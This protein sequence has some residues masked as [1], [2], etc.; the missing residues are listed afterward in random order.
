M[1]APAWMPLYV[2]DYLADTG[3]LSTL[4]HGAYLLLI[5]HY[6]QNGSLPTDEKKLARITRMRLELWR[7]LAPQ[8][9]D[10]FDDSWRHERIERELSE[11]SDI[12]SKRSKAGKAGA[13]GRWGK[14]NA[15][16]MA[17]ASKCQIPS[18]TPSPLP[19]KKE[20]EEKV[21]DRA[22]ARKRRVSMPFN[23][24]DEELKSA[25]VNFWQVHA[26][27]DIAA[28]VDIQADQFRDHHA[29]TGAIMADWPAAWRTWYRN[30]LKYNK[31][32]QKHKESGHE[33]LARVSANLIQEFRSNGRGNNHSDQ[34][35]SPE[36][37]DED[38]DGRTISPMALDV[39]PRF[40]GSH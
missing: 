29:K 11:A 31:I 23:F 39:L 32:A 3:H 16:A 25:A 33:Q 28:E 8:L 26:R 17:N 6:W 5:M 38:D 36:L 4:E 30:A 35:P 22:D 27:P 40:G 19:N 37:P 2:S 13:S 12:L 20:K 14:R 24:P 7:K 15:D 1:T 34:S 21:L 18:P 10:F 9:K